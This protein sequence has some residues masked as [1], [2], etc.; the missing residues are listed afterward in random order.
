M[1]RAD[2]MAAGRS[3]TN[4]DDDDGDHVLR[5]MDCLYTGRTELDG[6]I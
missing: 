5:V 4:V 1:L 6:H 2:F 3:S